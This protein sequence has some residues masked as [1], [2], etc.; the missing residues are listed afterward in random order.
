MVT[1]TL[2]FWAGFMWY[3]GGYMGEDVY[4]M[5]DAKFSMC[6]YVCGRW[7][8]MAVNVKRKSK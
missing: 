7:S 6:D 8:D 3:G 1:F 2:L 4:E 5:K